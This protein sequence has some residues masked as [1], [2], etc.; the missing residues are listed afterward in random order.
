ML[1]AYRLRKSRQYVLEFANDP[2]DQTLS[3]LIEKLQQYEKMGVSGDEKT[4]NEYLL[5]ITE[6]M[7]FP[8][9]G[10]FGIMT[11]LREFDDLTGGLQK[12]DLFIVAARPSVGKTAFA[13]QMAA[14]HAHQ[15]G[16]AHF[17]SLEMGIKPLLQRMISQEAQINSQKWHHMYFSA[18]DYER[19]LRAIGEMSTW[20][21]FMQDSVRSVQ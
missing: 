19:G 3:L 1:D 11:N 18:E 8:S 9:E 10:P 17:V 14:S 16:Y 20:P 2:S 13:L 4:L 7:C 15:G 5:A 21:L 6:E 12:G